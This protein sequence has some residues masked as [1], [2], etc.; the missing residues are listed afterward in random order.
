MHDRYD[1]VH[2]VR[3][4]HH[5]QHPAGAVAAVGRRIPR[6]EPPEC[7]LSGGADRRPG[8][9]SFPRGRHHQPHGVSAAAAARDRQRGGHRPRGRAGHQVR[10]GDSWARRRRCCGT[11]TGI[12]TP[13]SSTAPQRPS[14]V[15]RDRNGTTIPRTKPVRRR[16]AQRKRLEKKDSTMPY[17][18]A[19]EV[20]GPGRSRRGRSGRSWPSCRWCSAGSRRYCFGR[21]RDRMGQDVGCDL[22]GGGH[23]RRLPVGKRALAGGLLLGAAVARCG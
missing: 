3:R 20:G 9:R 18:V 2:E 23:T 7:P 10:G 19:D 21:S 16:L 17:L 6:S 13:I 5:P 15:H 1:S 4:R 11:D 14:P 22:V 8:W 12:T